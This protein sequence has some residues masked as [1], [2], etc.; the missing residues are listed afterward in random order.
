MRSVENKNWVE[1]SDTVAT[2]LV[3]P[4]R[5]FRAESSRALHFNSKG[6][7]LLGINSVEPYG[8]LTEAAFTDRATSLNLLQAVVKN[9]DNVVFE[10]PDGARSVGNLARGTGR[11]YA[12]LLGDV[13][14]HAGMAIG[15][16]LRS[17]VRV[18]L[19]RSD[20]LVVVR[21]NMDVRILP[22]MRL[23]FGVA[24]EGAEKYGQSLVHSTGV[25]Y[26]DGVEAALVEE[27]IVGM[28]NAG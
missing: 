11:A 16:L 6:K 19:L 1:L 25:D 5:A 14:R 7:E 20:D 3:P 10:I 21:E 23:D 17:E 4:F 27:V 2:D 12:E 15:A 26:A 13:F 24:E 18:P 9:V 8:A 22:P 28:Q